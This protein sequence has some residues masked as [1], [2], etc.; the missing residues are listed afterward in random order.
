M[1]DCCLSFCKSW[2]FTNNAAWHLSLLVFITHDSGQLT[3]YIS[4]QIQRAAIVSHQWPNLQALTMFGLAMDIAETLAQ[5][6]WPIFPACPQPGIN[7]PEG[8]EHG[9]Q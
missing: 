7:L 2:A 1:Q 8:W 3:Y 5:V 6:M 9:F 4:E